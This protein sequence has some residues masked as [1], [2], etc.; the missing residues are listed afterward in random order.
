MG[1]C[2]IYSALAALVYR[3]STHFKRLP[4]AIAHAFGD[5][6]LNF[7]PM[8]NLP[9]VDPLSTCFPSCGCT[10]RAAEDVIERPQCTELMAEI[11]LHRQASPNVSGYLG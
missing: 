2:P 6:H 8:P 5:S 3:C 9:A 10:E 4:H 11:G 1:T 7:D